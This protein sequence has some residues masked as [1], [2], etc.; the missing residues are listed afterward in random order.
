MEKSLWC[1]TSDWA[2]RKP[3]TEPWVGYG[4]WQLPLFAVDSTVSAALLRA[5]ATQFNSLHS[6]NMATRASGVERLVSPWQTKSLKPDV[7]FGFAG[8]QIR[9][10]PRGHNSGLSARCIDRWNRKGRYSG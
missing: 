10:S 8:L 1:S 2:A 9:F 4:H 6:L 7:I 5:V 3:C